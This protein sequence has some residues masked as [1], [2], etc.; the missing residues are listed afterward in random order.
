M[1]FKCKMKIELNGKKKLESSMQKEILF[2]NLN[3]KKC[4]FFVSHGKMSRFE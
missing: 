3:W 2:S 1:H 4:Q